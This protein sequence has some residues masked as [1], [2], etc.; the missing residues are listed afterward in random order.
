M[1]NDEIKLKASNVWLLLNILINEIEKG[2]SKNSM[3]I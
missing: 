1:N 3:N 2:F